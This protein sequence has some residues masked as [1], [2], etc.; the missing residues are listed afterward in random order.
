MRTVMICALLES[1]HSQASFDVLIVEIGPEKEALHGFQSYMYMGK[2]IHVD[3][4]IHK[5][6]HAL[7]FL[8]VALI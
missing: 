6:I 1:R 8:L 5:L 2:N 7:R 3:L 4:H